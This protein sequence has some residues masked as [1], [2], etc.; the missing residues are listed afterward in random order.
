MVGYTRS[1]NFPTTLDAFDLG[2]ALQKSGGT[3][4]DAFVLG[5]APG[6]QLQYSSYLGGTG[7]DLAFAVAVPPS[8]SDS[9][10]L[11]G[12][13]GSSDF[14]DKNASTFP[15]GILDCPSAAP[16]LGAGTKDAFVVKME[17]SPPLDKQP[18]VLETILYSDC[19]DLSWA[20]YLGG[21][22]VEEGLGIAI[23]SK[24]NGQGGF[25]LVPFVTGQTCSSDFPI[26]SAS[27]AQ[28]PGGGCDAFVA[29]LSTSVTG[30]ATLKYTTYLGGSNW[31]LARDISIGPW[32][33]VVAGETRSLD[34][35]VT[36]ISSS[37]NFEFPCTYQET[38]GGGI[39]DVFLAA[40]SASTASSGNCQIGQVQYNNCADLTYSTYLGGIE[41]DQAFA[42]SADPSGAYVTGQTCSTIDTNPA[43]PG[44]RFP[45]S[46]PSDSRARK[47][48]RCDRLRCL[49]HQDKSFWN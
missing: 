8:L 44:Y 6:G 31:D 39:S 19:G 4:L 35:P 26:E 3:D 24:D 29:Q 21:T 1:S 38:H 34:F 23:G 43:P 10:Y 9:L 16:C 25:D 27:F 15:L 30:K 46:Q 7:D 49:C 33:V 2:T 22:S 11:T 48:K 17:I 28:Q 45:A 20:I 36:G 47:R 40:V 18:C 41:D 13:T 5:L 14:P 12:T 42:V 37:S 32:G